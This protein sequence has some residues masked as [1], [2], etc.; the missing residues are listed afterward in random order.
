[1]RV[2]EN[3]VFIFH[4]AVGVT[5]GLVSEGANHFSIFVI[6]PVG[7]VHA[8]AECD[9]FIKMLGTADN[10][11]I[12]NSKFFHKP[13]GLFLFIYQIFVVIRSL[14]FF[15]GADAFITFPTEFWKCFCTAEIVVVQVEVIL[16]I[17]EGIIFFYGN[18]MLTGMS[19]K[20]DTGPFKKILCKRCFFVEGAGVDDVLDLRLFVNIA[21]L[22]QRTFFP[23]A[24]N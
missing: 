13:V 7:V 3:V 18:R 17:W 24:H 21:D 2:L 9:V 14:S 20:L 4:Y 8:T 6:F 22:Y 1:M 11:G 16:P 10:T 5:F 19:D 23:A 15:V 12:R